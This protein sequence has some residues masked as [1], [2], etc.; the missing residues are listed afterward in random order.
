MYQV[1]VATG[2][3]GGGKGLQ[4]R[5]SGQD[6]CTQAD[7]RIEVE[8]LALGHVGATG[9]V[10]NYVGEVTVVP[11][12]TQGTQDFLR[13]GGVVLATEDPGTHAVGG[14]GF[15]VVFAEVVGIVHAA[16]QLEAH[17]QILEI[18]VEVHR[19]GISTIV[20]LLAYDVALVALSGDGARQFGVPPVLGGAFVQE[21]DIVETD[22]QIQPEA[23]EQGAQVLAQGGIGIHF[24]LGPLA[25]TILL[26]HGHR[27]H[28]AVQG[29]SA[30][31]AIGLFHRE[32]GRGQLVQGFLDRIRIIALV[33]FRQAGHHANLHGGGTGDVHIHVGPEAQAVV[34][35]VG[36][37][38]VIGRGFLV[39]EVFL[40]VI[41]CRKIAEVMVTALE[42][43]LG[44][45]VVAVVTVN[46]FPPVHVGIG[47]RILTAVQGQEFG[48]GILGREAVQATGFVHHEAVGV[49]VGKFR[50]TE[51]GG[52]TVAVLGSHFEA[53]VL[54]AAGGNHHHA[55]TALYAIQRSGGSVLEHRHGFNLQS[56]DILHVTGQTIDQQQRAVAVQAHGQ[57]EFGL[58]GIVGAGAIL[59]QQTGELAVE[60][61]RNVRFGALLKELAS[62]AQARVG[63]Q[64]VRIAD[65]NGVQHGLFLGKGR[66]TC[67]KKRKKDICIDSF[68]LRVQFLVYQPGFCVIP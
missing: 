60:C 24:G 47:V 61:I 35:M 26:H 28:T 8:A 65:G 19:L 49:S 20:E 56:G 45:V 5:V 54:T 62:G 2:H 4:V 53:G 13:L 32:G 55:I 37:V 50:C 15:H 18:V 23:L 3:T 68:H 40:Q 67:Q 29:A 12:V 38:T 43:K 46:L 51:L 21:A 16:L 17:L 31:G 14:M 22:V 66:R 25:L 10:E 58:V 42:G 59:H 6:H 11:V 64:V 57:L 41:H 1:A 36:I 48:I 52:Q 44:A 7:G 33:E 9:V 63:I 27:V 30:V 34:V 39:H